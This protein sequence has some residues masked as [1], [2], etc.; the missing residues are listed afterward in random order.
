[1]ECLIVNGRA[2][3]C[4]GFT[5][6]ELLVVMVIIGSLLTIAVP[7]YFRS[8]DQAKEVVLVQDLTV[9]R[10]AIDQFYSDRGQYPDGLDELVTARYIRKLPVD[11]I[12]KQ[13]D[14]W[15]LVF[16]DDNET[17]GVIDV[18]SG[19]SALAANGTAFNEW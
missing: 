4:R 7:R 13:A 9:L 2:R 17:P 19:S 8:L 11:P 6:I 3:Y 14:T 10:N 12:T 15:E 1:M 18:R 5:L 16:S